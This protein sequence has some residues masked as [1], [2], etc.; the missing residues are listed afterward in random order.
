MLKRFTAGLFFLAFLCTEQ[1]SAQGSLGSLACAN[2]RLKSTLR[3]ALATTNQQK[4][5]NK[6]DINFY[7]LD[8]ALEKTST[9]IQGNTL[10]K[11]RV[12]MAPLDTFAFEL[13]QDLAIDSIVVNGTK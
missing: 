4:L 6:Y 3:T 8:V 5:M 11:A 12:K 13:H 10:I 1:V 7:K 9:Y 2:G